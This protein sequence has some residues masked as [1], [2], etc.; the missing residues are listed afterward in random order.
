MKE[1]LSGSPSLSRKRIGE[2]IR[3][4]RASSHRNGPSRCFVAL[5]DPAQCS[6][7][8]L[9][10][11]VIEK[12]QAFGNRSKQNLSSLPDLADRND[13]SKRNDTLRHESRAFAARFRRS[14][15]ASN[16]RRPRRASRRRSSFA[17]SAVTLIEWLSRQAGWCSGSAQQML[18]ADLSHPALACAA[19]RATLRARGLPTNQTVA[20]WRAVCFPPSA[21][22]R[23]LGMR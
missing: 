15:E 3:G 20:P 16:T 17:T 4:G 1:H 2:S 21:V 23:P 12:L 8:H 19:A 9:A 22:D 7:C 13:R 18:C 14:C 10:G 5:V 6:L 11:R